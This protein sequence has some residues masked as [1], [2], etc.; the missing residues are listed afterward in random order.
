MAFDTK[1]RKAPDLCDE[2]VSRA[3]LC[4]IG[5]GVVGVIRRVHPLLMKAIVPAFLDWVS[6]VDLII[7]GDR[8]LLQPAVFARARSNANITYKRRRLERLNQRVQL[9]G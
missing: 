6:R 7:I 2:R 9:P 1:E 3:A 4:T 8:P 5:K